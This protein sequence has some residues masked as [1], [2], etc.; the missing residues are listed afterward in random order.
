MI[1]DFCESA[2]SRN[3]H[4]CRATSDTPGD[5]TFLNVGTLLQLGGRQPDTTYPPNLVVGGFNGCI[6]NLRHNSKVNTHFFSAVEC[7][8]N[9]LNNVSDH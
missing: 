6:R 1:V 5:Y 8:K 9:I 4:P 3:D 7:W 2:A